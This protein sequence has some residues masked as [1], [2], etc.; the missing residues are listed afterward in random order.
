MTRCSVLVALGENLKDAR[1]VPSLAAHLSDSD[2]YARYDAFDGLRNLTHENACTL[3][4]DWR[5]QDVEPQIS[6]CNAWWQ[7]EGQFQSWSQR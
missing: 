7:Q 6:K 1:A 4:P 2:R 5:E 3:P